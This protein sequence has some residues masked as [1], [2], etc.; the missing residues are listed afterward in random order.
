MRPL[1][2]LVLAFIVIVYAVVLF[3][4]LG[5]P[6]RLL[7]DTDEACTKWPTLRGAPCY[8]M[9][10]LDEVHYVPD[11]RDVVRFG[12]ESDIRVPEHDGAYVVHPPV[13]KWFIAL[14]MVVF[15]DRPFGW[16]AF[17]CL[18]A[19]AGIVMVYALARR[20]WRSP[21]WAAFAALLLAV[22]GL[23][24]VQARV[25]MLDIYAATFTLA[26]VWLV[27]EARDRR[28]WRW[29]CAAG[30][31]L[32][33]ALATKW[34]PI[35]IIAVA[36]LLALRWGGWRALAT[37]GLI[38]LV[39][40][41]TFTPW[42]LDAHRYVP[43]AC[44]GSHIAG[45][46][47]AWVCYQQEMY[48]F[49]RD[50]QKYEPKA[51]DDDEASATP[52]ADGATPALVPGHPYFGHGYSWPWIGRPVAHHYASADDKAEEVLG[53]PNPATWWTAFFLGIPAL[54]ILALRRDGTAAMLLALIA[55]AYLPYLAADLVARPVFLFYATPLVPY[56]V[57]GLTHLGVRA[58]R[59]WT[60]AGTVAVAFAMIAVT[61][62]VYFYPVLSS[63]PVPSASWRARIWLSRD[64]S[65]EGRIKIAC[66]I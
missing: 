43:P 59:R 65:A 30:V 27:V 51:A 7:A 23:W 50:L 31:A 35:P 46:F 2:A 21:W 19:I 16:R 17:G 47:G 18:F 10:P 15:G 42:F 8:E 24:F 52:T 22:D 62:A 25:A 61:L 13:G 3:S 60:Q 32:G 4:R 20:L 9:I 40:V 57:L 6:G 54:L 12:T 26:G 41:A 33:L 1:D 36:V 37:A 56:L 38:P 66:W 39:Y 48:H 53:L 14:G 5:H 55:A 63:S 44:E 45:R 64:C 29:W 58:A 49:H 28:S 11:A 34:G